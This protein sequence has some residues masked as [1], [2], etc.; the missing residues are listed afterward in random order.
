MTWDYEADWYHPDGLEYHGALGF[1]KGG[2]MFAD[3]ITTVSPTYAS[4]ILTSE[5]GMGLEGV[6]QA[7]SAVLSGILNGIDTGVWDPAER[8]CTGAHL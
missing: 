5:Y 2:L 4:E 8:S 6:L 1:L 3:R 7:R